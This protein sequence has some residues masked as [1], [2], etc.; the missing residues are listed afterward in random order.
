MYP[1]NMS[2]PFAGVPQVDAATAYR[3]LQAG[4][5]SIVD[6]REPEEWELGH[7]D[8]ISHIPLDQLPARWRELDPDSE[9]VCVCLSGVRSNYAATLLQRLGLDATN[10][11]GGMLDWHNRQ[12]PITPPGIIGPH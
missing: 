3:Q 1:R 7:I 6:V 4:E 5:V 12:L 9:W 11:A 10:L 2:D 8:G